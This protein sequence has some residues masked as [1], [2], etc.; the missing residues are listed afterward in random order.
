M[1][2]TRSGLGRHQRGITF[3]GMLFV[4]AVVGSVMVVGAQV[5]PTVVEY[6]AVKK[7]VKKA[8]EGTTVAEV[9]DIFEH[10]TEVD[11]ITSVT[12]NDLDI[13]KDGDR[14]VVSFAYNKEIH[15]VGPAYLLLKYRGSSAP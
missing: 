13:T 12:P 8:S 10:A 6:L 2:I 14:V 11:A 5:F 1:R 3:I 9:R 7:A 15:L 4:A